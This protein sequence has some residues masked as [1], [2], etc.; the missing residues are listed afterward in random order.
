[1]NRTRSRTR[2][3]DD[4]GRLYTFHHRA[5]QGLYGQQADHQIQG[6]F[7]RQPRIGEKSSSHRTISAGGE[8]PNHI[9]PDSIFYINCKAEFSLH[10]RIV[11]GRFKLAPR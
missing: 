8:L 9:H 7:Y 3:N 10:V 6:E 5:S 4:V 11:G 1:M 2:T